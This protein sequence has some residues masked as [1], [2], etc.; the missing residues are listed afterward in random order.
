MKHLAPI[1]LLA[2]LLLSSCRSGSGP[3]GLPGMAAEPSDEQKVARVLA[4]VAQGMENKRVYQVLSHVSQR[5]HDRDGRDYEALRNYVSDILDNYRTIR[6]T[7]TPSRI[8]VQGDRARVVDTF[9]TLA[10]PNDAKQ[11]PIVDLQGR[12]VVLMER[13]G[14]TW[15][16]LEWGPLF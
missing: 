11:Y 15:Q 3:F 10:E 14:D 4:D 12:V 5:Y 1:A 2:A 6:V 16:I 13:T 7:R 9:G 8:Q